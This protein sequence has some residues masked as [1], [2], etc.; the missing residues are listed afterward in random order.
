MSTLNA[1]NG[2]I[3]FPPGFSLTVTQNVNITSGGGLELSNSVVSI[4]GNFIINSD[5][6]ATVYLNGGPA[7]QLSIGGNLS[8]T[9]GRLDIDLQSATNPALTIPGALAVN[10]GNLLFHANPTNTGTLTVGG[11]LSATNSGLV[12]L[13]S[14]MT[15][16]TKAYGLL[17]NVASNIS[18]ATNSWVYPHSHLTNGGSVHFYAVNLVVNSGGGIDATGGGFG[19]GIYLVNSSRGYGPGTPPGAGTTHPV[20]MAVAWSMLRRRGP[21][22]WMAASWR[23]EA[24]SSQALVIPTVAQGQAGGSTSDA[25][26]SRVRPAAC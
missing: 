13:Y 14:S 20:R 9:Q 3:A 23:S 8:V 10:A 4:G 5:R 11:G 15:N 19:G 25:G 24:R 6:K 26:H 21:S 22:S 16:G 18:I 12:H 1:S 7:Q 2:L 17:V